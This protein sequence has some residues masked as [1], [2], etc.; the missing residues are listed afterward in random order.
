MRRVNQPPSHPG[1]AYG[2]GPPP[3]Q[4]YGYGPQP[5]PAH[6]GYPQGVQ[7]PV[8][9]LASWGRRCVAR[10]ID[11]VPLYAL[12]YGIERLGSYLVR[13]VWPGV[14]QSRGFLPADIHHDLVGLGRALWMPAIAVGVPFLYEWLMLG[15]KGRT[16][17]K[18]VMKLRTADAVT[19]QPLPPLLAR[20]RAWHFPLLVNLLGGLTC[21]VFVLIDALWPLWDKPL[22]QALHDK[23]AHT[24]VIRIDA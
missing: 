1:D 19:G 14:L 16:V 20:R 23:W 17:G 22:G 5:V 4:P 18:M 13:D 8:S 24:I 21:G 2:Y 10:V 12:M 7:P 3:G 15:S 11:W 6:G 9:A